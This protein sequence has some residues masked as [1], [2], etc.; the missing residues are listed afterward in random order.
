MLLMDGSGGST[1]R[2]D[3][4]LRTQWNDPL[5]PKHLFNLSSLMLARRNDVTVHSLEWTVTECWRMSAS[6]RPNASGVSI[7]VH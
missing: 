2:G 5:R 3:V 1:R 7:T 6:P 4:L